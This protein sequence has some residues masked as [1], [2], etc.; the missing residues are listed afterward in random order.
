MLPRALRLGPGQLAL[1]EQAVRGQQIGRLAVGI[2]L[3]E[4]LRREHDARVRCLHPLDIVTARDRTGV[5]GLATA[6]GDRG[7]RRRAVG[8]GFVLVS[9]IGRGSI[10]HGVLLVA[11]LLGRG[12]GRDGR[13]RSAR[14]LRLSH[15]RNIGVLGVGLHVRVDDLGRG[16]LVVVR[17]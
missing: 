1:V 16:R 3:A 14:L 9:G 4:P 2:E 5:V 13:D 11:A 12:I 7:G 6:D 8:D 10:C 17:G 15:V